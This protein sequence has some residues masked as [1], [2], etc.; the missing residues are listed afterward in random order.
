MTIGSSYF[1]KEGEAQSDRN[2]RKIEH[3]FWKMKNEPDVRNFQIFASQDPITVEQAI[4]MRGA[5]K[6]NKD[7]STNLVQLYGLLLGKDLSGG[8]GSL[9]DQYSLL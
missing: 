7:V 5:D 1:K 4:K 2:I 3:S 9:I 6:V 8:K